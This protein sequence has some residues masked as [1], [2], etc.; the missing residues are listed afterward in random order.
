MGVHGQVQV[1]AG[2]GR[3]AGNVPKICTEPSVSVDVPSIE[4][5]LAYSNLLLPVHTHPGLACHVLCT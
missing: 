4:S 1:A 5:F 2:D 3:G